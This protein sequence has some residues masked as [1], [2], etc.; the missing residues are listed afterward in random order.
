MNAYI[1]LF[2]VRGT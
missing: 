2:D 1:E